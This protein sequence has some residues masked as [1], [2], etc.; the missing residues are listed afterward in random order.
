MLLV[1]VFVISLTCYCPLGSKTEYVEIG[2]P[3]FDACE[4]VRLENVPSAA[5]CHLRTP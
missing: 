1:W 2:F 4:T 5:P 3:S